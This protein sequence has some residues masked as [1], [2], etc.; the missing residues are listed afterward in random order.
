MTRRQHFV[1]ILILGALSTISPFSIDMYLPGFPAIA[2]DLR[3]S[4]SQV[5]LSLTAYLVGISVGQLLYGPLLDRFGRKRPLFAGLIVYGIASIGCAF[6]SSIEMLIA[7]RLLQALGG[8]V[9]LVAAQALVRDLFPVGEI[10][11]V[12][13][14]LTLVVAVSPMIA[15][16]VGGYATVAFGWHSIFVILAIITVL[17]LAGVYFVLPNGKAPDASL[18]LRPKAVMGSFFTVLKQP[19]FLTYTLVGGIA[20]SAPFAYLAGSSDVFMNI[21]HVSAQEYGWIFAF[22]AIAMIGPTQLNRFLLRRF[23]NEQIIFVTLIY[24]T[25]VGVL[26]VLGTWAGWYGQYGLIGML[27]LFLGGQGIT[28]PNASAL[29]LAPFSR[30]AGSAAA[31]MGSFRMGFGSLVSASVS[32]LHNNTAIPMVGVMTGCITLGVVILLIGERVIR[33]Q[34][35]ANDLDEPMSEVLL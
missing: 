11:Q 32:L 34:A 33:Q 19:Q 35:K 13:S 28:N 23:S 8:C 18:S 7:M 26:L 6:S 20:T 27:F 14:L 21:Y 5:Q 4:I 10:A 1:I 12:F 9:G 3:T 30:H 16:T 2:R 15:P 25:V 17:M 29:S 31:L 24:Q 22:L